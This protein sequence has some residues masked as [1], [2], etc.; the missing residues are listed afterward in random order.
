MAG[1]LAALFG[2]STLTIGP[3]EIA[4]VRRAAAEAL[5]SS[6]AQR[7]LALNDIALPRFEDRRHGGRP[8]EAP[9]GEERLLLEATLDADHLVFVAPVY[10]YALPAA[11]KLYLDYWSAW[12]RVPGYDFKPRMAGKALSAVTIISSEDEAEAEPLIGCL[13]LTADYMKM[14][15][16]GALIGHGNRP[17][18]VAGDARAIDA[19]R[20]FFGA[21][22][23]RG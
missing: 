22:A 6:A 19:A 18:D 15:W 4:S 3:D 20:R 16:R 10:W 11:A 13:R 1:L 12:L 23:A 9:E 2:P 7:W 5:P 21:G 14:E 17:G 8:F